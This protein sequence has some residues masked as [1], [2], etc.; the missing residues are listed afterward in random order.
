[1]HIKK[2]DQVKII[3]GKD[4]NKIGEVLKVFP[5]KKS[6]LVNKVNI[7]KK[8][9]KATKDNA[10]GITEKELPIGVSKLM[11]ICVKCNKATR[12]KNEILSDGKKVRI[13]KKCGE[14]I[15]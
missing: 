6:V 14:I 5:T 8:S 15:I 4:K 1:M 13:C 10:G 11:L 12:I 3:S 9:V 2:K 7:V